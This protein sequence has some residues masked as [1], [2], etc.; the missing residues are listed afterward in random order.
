[1]TEIFSDVNES[2][3]LTLEVSGMRLDPNARLPSPNPKNFCLNSPRV[4][5]GSPGK[6]LISHLI[7]TVELSSGGGIQTLLAY[8]SHL[9]LTPRR[10]VINIEQGQ[11]EA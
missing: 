6:N 7:G 8:Q 10:R 1:M 5:Q 2:N 4:L 9:L 11:H 3:L